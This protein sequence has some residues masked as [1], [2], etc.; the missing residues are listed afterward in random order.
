MKTTKKIW[1]QT[2]YGQHSIGQPL[3]DLINTDAMQRLKKM[4][5]GHAVEYEVG[6][7]EKGPCAQAVKLC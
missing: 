5:N 1:M 7:T 2:L 4:Y 3:I 6:E